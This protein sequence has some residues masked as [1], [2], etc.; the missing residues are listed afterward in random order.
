M[1]LSC[2]NI[3]KSYSNGKNRLSVLKD[4]SL[5]MNSGEV[6]GIIGSSGAGKSTLLNILGT[7]DKPDSGAVLIE[8]KDVSKLSKKDTATLRNKTLGFVFQFHHLLPEFTAIENVM[9]PTLIGSKRD[10]SRNRAIEWFNFMELSSRMSHY[11]Q[12][13]SGGERQRVAIMRALIQ[14]PAIIF[15]DEP[16]GNLDK[17]NTK[18]LLDLFLKIKDE[19]NQ[20]FLIATHDPLVTQITDRTYQLI[21]STLH[22]TDNL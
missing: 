21:N 15:A 20:S 7:L 2:H 1:I 6:V 4:V 19:F 13:L 8:G 17:D 14:Q 9:I 10:S 22:V 18:I 12:Q 3:C 5:E 11:P 16:T